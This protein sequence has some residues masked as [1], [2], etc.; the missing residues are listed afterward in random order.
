MN[1]EE[2]KLRRLEKHKSKRIQK[3]KIRRKKALKCIS[4][5]IIIQLIIGIVFWDLYNDCKMATSKN[6]R[7]AEFIADKIERP[8]NTARIR[9]SN[10]RIYNDSEVYYYNCFV[11][12]EDERNHLSSHHTMYVTYIINYSIIH[13]ETNIVVELQNGESTYY[14]IDDFNRYQ[15]KQRSLCLIVFSFFEFIYLIVAFLAILINLDTMKQN[16]NDN[17]K[18]RQLFL[19]GRNKRR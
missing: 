19:I 10:I 13:G 14:T 9:S 8:L 5:V 11:R 7:T 18:F 4:I 6:V 15:E 1:R 17:R 16:H 12:S 2:I 3:Y